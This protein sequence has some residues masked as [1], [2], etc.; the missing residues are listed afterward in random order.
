[1]GQ[2]VAQ[3][4][5]NIVMKANPIGIVITL[6]GG[7]I[8]VIIKLVKHWD[9]IKAAF[10]RFFDFL[11]GM[12]GPMKLIFKV[13]F[14]PINLIIEAIKNL[15]AI[16]ERVKKIGGFFGKTFGKIFGGKARIGIAEDVFE[17]P[18]PRRRTAPIAPAPNRKQ[19]EA[20]LG[21]AVNYRG[22]LEIAGAPPGSKLTERITGAKSAPILI[23]QLG[24]NF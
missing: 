4:A 23:E 8:F 12:P 3:A 1:M 19:V 6:V 11:S 21:G 22:R 15:G 17:A 5:L 9:K 7:L 13:L 2:T 14:A 24:G 10:S 18:E 20:M 16:W